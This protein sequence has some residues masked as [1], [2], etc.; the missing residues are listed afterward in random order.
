[1]SNCEDFCICCTE[2][3]KFPINFSGYHKVCKDH[4][5]I[6]IQ[7]VTC[8]R[9]ET[10]IIPIQEFLHCTFCGNQ[11]TEKC[12]CGS[13]LCNNCSVRCLACSQAYCSVCLSSPTKDCSQCEEFNKTHCQHCKNPKQSFC[14]LCKQH[15]CNPTKCKC[16][17]CK[18]I[19][20]VECVQNSDLCL[21]CSS[22][23]IPKKE[24]KELDEEEK[25]ERKDF[26]EEEKK[27]FKE[28]ERKYFKVDEKKEFE[29]VE[30]KISLTLSNRGTTQSRL[31]YC[32]WCKLAKEL[33]VKKC[34][35]FLCDECFKQDCQ[36]CLDTANGI[37]RLN[38]QH[39]NI[40]KLKK[41]Q[42]CKEDFEKLK[43]IEDYQLCDKC[44]SNMVTQSDNSKCFCENCGE[45]EDRIKFMCT[46]SGCIKCFNNKK[47]CF[48]C[49]FE[50]KFKVVLKDEICALCFKQSQCAELFCKHFCCQK[51]MKNI[52]NI[53]FLCRD[54]LVKGD[55]RC[56]K[57]HNFSIWE[58]DKKSKYMKKLCCNLEICKI[59][60]Q[61]KSKLM[62][63]R[64]KVVA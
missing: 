34:G 44:Y 11:V 20:C 43:K 2:K 26:K 23:L 13:L 39:V 42:F 29:E 51:C 40:K 47:V 54:C 55:K 15:N 57:C 6:N 63:C 53:N 61:S 60:F 28:E 7:I 14:F 22:Q 59:C 9:C 19:F 10:E 18:K 52:K 62:N 36:P 50:K 4:L 38:T 8:S 1:M 5:P 21:T 64:C 56:L 58:D 46:H 30:K 16:S 3:G 35:H 32:D 41:C 37:K 49:G 17:K 33:K 31:K 24:N 45:K 25:K 48:K 27:Y 12:L